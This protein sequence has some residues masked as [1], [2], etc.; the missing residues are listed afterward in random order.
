MQASRTLACSSSAGQEQNLAFRKSFLYSARI[1]RAAVSLPL[2]VPPRQPP[3]EG[4]DHGW[5]RRE[6]EALHL[7]REQLAE[8]SNVGER[9]IA[10]W[11]LREATPQFK[12][13]GRVEEALARERERR[14]LPTTEDR[15]RRIEAINLRILGYVEEMV[16]LLRR[17]EQGPPAESQ[18]DA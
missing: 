1:L 3:D 17:R 10:S 15:L 2:M 14:G 13:A 6:R 16:E 4:T 7:T 5:P 9:T 18:A 12:L 8:R 11:E